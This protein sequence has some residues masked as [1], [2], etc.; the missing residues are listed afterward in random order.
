MIDITDR[1]T[2]RKIL[3]D[4]TKLMRLA[5]TSLIAIEED[6]HPHIEALS[7]EVQRLR[8]FLQRID[9]IIHPSPVFIEPYNTVEYPKPE[10][11]GDQVAYRLGRIEKL[12]ASYEKSEV[13]RPRPPRKEMDSNE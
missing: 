11:I 12:M 1:L 6:P 3:A 8:L 9:Q 10:S 4:Y 2:N 13:C 5:E 7:R